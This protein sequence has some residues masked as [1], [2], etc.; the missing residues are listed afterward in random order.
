MSNYCLKE[1]YQSRLE[2]AYYVAHDTGINWQHAV[3]DYALGLANYYGYHTIIDIGCGDGSKL[4]PFVPAFKVIGMGYGDNLNY[5]RQRYPDSAWLSCNLDDV[6]TYPE[7]D[8]TILDGALIICADVI[9]H[10]VYPDILLSVLSKWLNDTNRAILS[11]PERDLVHGYHHMGMPPNPCHVREWNAS[12][13]LCL[14]EQWHLQVESAQC[15]PAY[16]GSQ[17]NETFVVTI[18]RNDDAYSAI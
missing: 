3:Y 4:Q 1:G 7:W 11:T 5:C 10:L 8:A 12:E 9:E 18:K 16:E 6:S 2:P 14:M 17:R 13:F 15:V